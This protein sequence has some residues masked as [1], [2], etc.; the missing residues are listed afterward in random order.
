MKIITLQPKEF[1]NY[2]KKHKYRSYYQSSAYGNTMV[3]FG[4]NVHYLGIIDETERL[5]GAGLLLYKEVF[6]NNKYAYAPRGILFDYDK[7]FLV[8]EFTERLK[9]LLGKQGFMY[10]K[11]DPYIPSSIKDVS[12]NMITMNNDINII[13]ANLKNADFTYKGKNLFFENEKAR[14]EALVTLDNDIKEIYNG[15]SKN[16]RHKIKKAMRFGVEIY[17]DKSLDV[18]ELYEFIKNKHSRPLEYYKTLCEEFKPNIDLYYAKL[19]TEAFV[20]NSKAAYENELDKND[21]L[22]QKIQYKPGSKEE[23]QKLLNMK[24]ES[25]KL[26]NIYKNNLVEATDL[27]SKYPQGLTIGGALAIIYDNAAYLVI[28]GFNKNYSYL[29]PNYLLKWNMIRD[30]YHEQLKY[31]NLNAVTGDFSK[32]GDNK[33]EGLNEMKFSFN[34]IV[35]ENIGE[36]EIILNSL[37]YNL[38]KSLNKKK[39]K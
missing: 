7:S 10:L 32:K 21:A 17:K 11:M 14:F 29:N 2:A 5:I 28:E 15:F 8:K 18:T 19:N 22:A 30:Y 34:P 26:I 24:M 9:A 23:Q 36:F 20:V 38:Y 25:D 13:M 27:L 16:T 33:Y 12:G 1:D 39:E 37:S 6:M 35:V 3:K 31:F 4:W